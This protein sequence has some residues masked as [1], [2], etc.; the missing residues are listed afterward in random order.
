MKLNIKKLTVIRANAALRP[1]L[2]R[3]QQARD[4]L[5]IAL[6]ARCDDEVV[7]VDALAAAQGDLVVLG[8]DGGGGGLDPADLR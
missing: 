3:L 5:P 4:L 7:V 8:R 6:H 2:Q 1:L